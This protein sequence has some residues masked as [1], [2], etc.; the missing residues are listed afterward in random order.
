MK[1]AVLGSG[2]GALAVAADVSR[3]GRHTVLADL[4][5]AG[6]ASTVALWWLNVP[7][8]AAEE[9]CTACLSRFDLPDPTA[10]SAWFAPPLGTGS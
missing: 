2:G 1:V 10:L 7:M 4:V 9:A 5:M 3:H 8:S 6:V